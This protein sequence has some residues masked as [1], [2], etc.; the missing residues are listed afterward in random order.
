[1]PGGKRPKSDIIQEET[2]DMQLEF[3]SDDESVTETER[4][5]SLDMEQ[6]CI[7]YLPVIR[8]VSTK[9]DKV[10]SAVKKH[11]ATIGQ[12]TEQVDKLK[13]EVKELK[14]QNQK[15]YY[16]TNHKNLIMSG[17]KEDSN[18]TDVTDHNSVMEIFREKLNFK[19][20][21]DKIERIG[22]KKGNPERPRLLKIKFL[23]T[24]ERDNI[25]RNKKQIGYPYYI[26]E[27]LSPGQRT[28]RNKLISEAKKAKELNKEVEIIWNKSQIKINGALYQVDSDRLIAVLNKQ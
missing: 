4:D 9:L 27:D 6:L 1:M 28:T 7:K 21:I 15:L 19:P 10:C 12:L 26:S 2:A 22:A 5:D 25:W 14:E 23:L 20:T 24:R 16:F 18:T 3:D 8:K 11:E 13:T 17:I